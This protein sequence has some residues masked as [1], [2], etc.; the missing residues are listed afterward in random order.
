MNRWNQQVPEG[1]QDFLP[2]ECYQKRKIEDTLRRFFYLNGYDEIDTPIFEYLDVFSGSKA[3]IE[4]EQMYKFFEPGSRI[5]VLRPD[6]TMP[7]ARIAATKLKERPLPLRLSYSS[8]VYRY[9]EL[10]SAKQREVAQA[11]IE[12]LGAKGPEAD[13]EVIAAGIQAFL[14]MGLT[15]FQMDIGQVEFFK[16][17]VEEAGLI[18]EESEEIRSLIDHKNMLSLEMFLKERPI[19]SDVKNNLMR[20]PMLFGNATML[21]EAMKLSKNPRCQSA[22]ENIGKVYDILKQYGLSQYITFDLGMVQSL[23]YYTG[24]IFRGMTR[25]LGFPICGGGR[26]DNLLAEYGMDIPA[27]GFAIGLK[28]VLMALERQHGLEPIPKTD[29]LFV[30][31]AILDSQGYV[32]M[33]SMRQQGLRVEA[34]LP[35]ENSIED[36][37]D[38]ARRRGIPR[39]IVIE[40]SG[41]EEIEV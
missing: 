31:D 32:Q 29:V 21:K 4:Q 14:E 5:M 39:I 19:P 23:H 30:Y 9:E 26:Y 33:Q 34:Y 6:I 17:L 3:S 37:K 13:A 20:L 8:S 36:I 15:E 24:I 11:G 2:E 7:I 41:S 18:E 25:E 27:T 40:K 12:L 1:V 16:G 10:Q 35:K 38:F 28:R 22:I